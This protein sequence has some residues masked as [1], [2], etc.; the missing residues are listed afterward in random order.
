[1]YSRWLN[2]VAELKLI[3]LIHIRISLIIIFE[4][5]M[6]PYHYLMET[7]FRILG[8]L[9]IEFWKLVSNPRIF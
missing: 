9:H 2:S 7:V 8:K 1:M 5:L 3:I 4:A 6:K